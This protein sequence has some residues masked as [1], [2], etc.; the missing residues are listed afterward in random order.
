MWNSSKSVLLSSIC[1]KLV[2]VL[3]IAFAAL[4]PRLIMYYISFVSWGLQFK[5]MVWFMIILYVCCVPALVALVC[6]DRL[7]SNIK[8][9]DV[10]IKKNVTFLRVISWCCFAVAISLL[11][12]TYYY[13]ICLVASIV[14]AFIGLILRVVK[15][16]I[17]Q[18][19]ILKTESDFTI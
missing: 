3:V 5:D 8:R 11:L 14:A 15:N 7:L 9:G 12:A 13:L 1:T 10:F 18:A 6:L 17:E 19:V 4:L 16:V 2:M